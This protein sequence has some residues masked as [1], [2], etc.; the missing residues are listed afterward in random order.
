MPPNSAVRATRGGLVTLLGSAGTFVLQFTSVTVL[1]RLLAP[2]D[3]GLVAMVG[4]FVALGNLLRD[5]GLP[6]AALQAKDLSQQQASNLFWVNSALALLAAS[7]LSI[8]TPLLVRLYSEQRLVAVV[9]ALAAV[10]LVNGVGA[11]IQVDL[12]RR[13]RFLA[14]VVSDVASQ[15]AGLIVAI[16]LATL[17]AGYWSLVAQTLVAAVSTLVARWVASGWR[18]VRPR[19]GQGSAPLFRSGA[20]LGGA[21]FLTFLQSNADTLVIGSLLGAQQLGYYNRAYQLLAAP[22]SRVLDP[23]TQVVLPAAN[24][25]AAEG[26]S[27]SGL[28]LRLQF[29]LGCVVVWVFATAAGVAPVLLPVVLGGGWGATVDVFRILAVGGA[30]WVFSYVSYWTFL[31]K[32]LSRELLRYNLVTK[33]LSV[34]LLCAGSAFGIRGVALGYAVG[35]MISWPINLV[36]LSRTVG[37]PAL[38][39][40]GNGLAILGIGALSALASGAATAVTGHWP[41]LPSLLLAGAAGTLVWFAILAVVPGLR[42]QAISSVALVR[43]VFSSGKA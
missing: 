42:R 31:L 6:V 36:W 25:H 24:R 35:M 16:V 4:V 22:V 17:G 39:F 41:P 37:F 15:F 13:M 32:D 18:P 2:E 27:V 9:P 21:Y 20:R 34:A 40:A 1:S 5:F 14:L 23:L 38:R 3:F 30:V 28:L 19:F 11:Q 43:S 29:A 33:P 7:A 8:S 12:A 26:R 10:I